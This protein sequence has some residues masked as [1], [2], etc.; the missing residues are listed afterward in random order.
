LANLLREHEP[1]DGAQIEEILGHV[2]IQMPV[3]G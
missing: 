2:E 1:V 3:A